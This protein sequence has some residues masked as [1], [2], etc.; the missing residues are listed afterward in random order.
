MSQLYKCSQHGEWLVSYVRLIR[1]ATAGEYKILPYYACP[2]IGCNYVKPNKWRKAWLADQREVIALQHLRVGVPD[3]LM[4]ELKR[5][6]G[7]PRMLDQLLKEYLEKCG[8][9]Q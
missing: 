5:N 8:G 6:C 7:Y 3:A 2:M 4:H 1:S 9:S